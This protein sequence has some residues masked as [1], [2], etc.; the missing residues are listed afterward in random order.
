MKVL[1]Y[2]FIVIG[3]LDVGS[4]WVLP[5][6]SPIDSIVGPTIGQFT[7]FIFLGIGYFLTSLNSNSETE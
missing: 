7:G 6:G 2:I 5:G 1:G 3:I 4:S